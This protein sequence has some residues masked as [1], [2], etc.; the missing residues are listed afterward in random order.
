MCKNDGVSDATK[1][2]AIA[3]P[4]P[5]GFSSA[6]KTIIGALLVTSIGLL[7]GVI[8]LA[9][10]N[11]TKTTTNTVTVTE[12]S[13]AAISPPQGD[14]TCSGAKI[15][16]PN[17]QCVINDVEQVG[18]QSGA[19]VTKGYNGNLNTTVVPITA[20]YYQAG[21][22]PVNVHWHLGTEHLSVGQYDENGT[23]RHLYAFFFSVDS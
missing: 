1:G 9:T 19:N 14:N 13:F 17:V 5:T 10:E 20:P 23:L 7:V 15:D 18:G 16:L 6:A 3:P 4:A 12:M 2:V 21:L 11:D 22:C 8:V